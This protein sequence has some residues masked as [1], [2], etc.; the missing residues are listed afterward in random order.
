MI[1]LGEFLMEK[2]DL[3]PLSL[4]EFHAYCAHGREKLLEEIE[5]RDPVKV[6]IG[7]IF[8]SKKI[9]SRQELDQAVF[10]HYRSEGW[11][12]SK[13]TAK[14]IYKLVRNEE[15]RKIR[16]ATDVSFMG[17]ILITKEKIGA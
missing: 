11:E 10:E 1:G 6:K 9:I 3:V 15:Q 13:G 7:N 12:V 16:I 4:E 5:K 2:F 17:E 8:F 14:N